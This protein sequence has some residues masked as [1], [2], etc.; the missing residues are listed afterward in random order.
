LLARALIDHLDGFGVG[1]QLADEKHLVSFFGMLLIWHGSPPKSSPLCH[2]LNCHS[3]FLS[4]S[5]CS[6][7]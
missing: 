4:L 2:F 6:N 7:T 3:V 5:L 1:L